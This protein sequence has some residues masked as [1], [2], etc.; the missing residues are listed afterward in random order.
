MTQYKVECGRTVDGEYKTLHIG[1]FTAEVGWRAIQQ[2][3]EEWSEGKGDRVF[4]IVESKEG[5]NA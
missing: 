2:A 3:S 1:W 4:R 5:D